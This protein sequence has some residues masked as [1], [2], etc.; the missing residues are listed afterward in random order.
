MRRGPKCEQFTDEFGECDV[1]AWQDAMDDYADAVYESRRDSE[2]EE[3]LRRE[4]EKKDERAR[5]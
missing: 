4:K 1:E 2:L 3:K 5:Q